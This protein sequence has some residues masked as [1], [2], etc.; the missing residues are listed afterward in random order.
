MMLLYRFCK[1][2]SVAFSFLFILLEGGG[3]SHIVLKYGVGYVCGISCGS[4]F[5]VNGDGFT[6]V[7]VYISIMVSSKTYTIVVRYVALFLHNG[8]GGIVQ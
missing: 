1:F 5:T 2:L 3:K 6:V 4:N 7:S 8:L